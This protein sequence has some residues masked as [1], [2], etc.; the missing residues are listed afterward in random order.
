MDE[1]IHVL[2]TK[3]HD[4]ISLLQHFLSSSIFPEGVLTITTTHAQHIHNNTYTTTHTQQHIH[5]NTTTHTQQHIHNNTYTTTHTQQH[6]H[7]NTYT[8]THTQQHIHNKHKH[9]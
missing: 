2:G 7:N 4:D 6:I 8:T 9:S 5:N 3:S 1:K